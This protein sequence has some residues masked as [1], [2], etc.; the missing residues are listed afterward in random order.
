MCQFAFPPGVSASVIVMMVMMRM[1]M[2]DV[3]VTVLF[4]VMQYL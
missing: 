4:A 3:R 2:N 1:K